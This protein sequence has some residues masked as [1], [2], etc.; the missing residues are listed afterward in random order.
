MELDLSVYKTNEEI[1]Q[2]I[3]SIKIQGATNVALAVF[4]GMELASSDKS[5]EEVISV[6]LQLANMR[7][8][9]PLAKNAVKYVDTMVKVKGKGDVNKLISQLSSDF[10]NLLVTAKKE[11]ISN[12]QSIGENVRNA[13][14]HCHSSTVEGILI[15]FAKKNEKFHVYCTETR[16]LLQGRITSTNLINAGVDTTLLVD[17]AAESVIIG[18][19][20]EPVDVVFT[21]A[22][23]LTIHGDAINKI[24]SFGIALAAYFASKP[25]YVV[26]S[27]LK[28]NPQTAYQDVQ[29]EMRSQQEVWDNPPKG[30]KLYNPAFEVIPNKLITGYIT[31]AGIILPSDLAKTVHEKY[32]WIF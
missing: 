17:S 5:I 31:E 18:R 6:G 19:G 29:I 20:N 23:E 10:L 3:K 22:D 8:N 7:P 1:A 15:S 32:D 21:G 13:F 25:L 12:S 27:L 16:P 24:G 2:D 28:V 9:E 4:R 11:M 30:L 14:T 26:A